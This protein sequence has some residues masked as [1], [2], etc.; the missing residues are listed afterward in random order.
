MYEKGELIYSVL[1]GW[2]TDTG[3]FDSLLKANQLVADK[4]N[5]KLSLNTK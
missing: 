1:D 4:K 5:K 3:T 2:W